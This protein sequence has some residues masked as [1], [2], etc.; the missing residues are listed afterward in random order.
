MVAILLC[1][2]A[3]MVIGFAWYS[4]LLFAK[5]W[6]KLSGWTEKQMKENQ[7]SGQMAKTYGISTLTSLVMAYVL[8]MLMN[9]SGINSIYPALMTA[10]WVWL[11][12][13]ATTSI[14]EV[15]YMKRS[16]TL[17]LI[18]T[19]YQLATLLVMAVILVLV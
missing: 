7:K 13:V 14:T 4:P 16:W 12:F 19:G 9:R 8:N 10:F 6:M 17:Y 5:P 1:T 3:S 18:N 2:V 15:L 11:G